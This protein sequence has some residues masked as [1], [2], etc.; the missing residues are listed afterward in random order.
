MGYYITIARPGGFIR[1]E[2][3]K[4]LVSGQDGLRLCTEPL[5]ATS[6]NSGTIEIPNQPGDTELYFPEQYEWYVVFHY[7][8]N[9][10]ITFK[11]PADWGDPGCLVKSI[12]TELARALQADITGEEGEIYFQ[13]GKPGLSKP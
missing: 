8:S 11:A 4:E 6:A 1:L 3:W 5:R 12:A 7:T 2:E 9:Y 13:Y 10:D